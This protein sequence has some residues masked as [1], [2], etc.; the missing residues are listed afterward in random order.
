MFRHMTHENIGRRID[1]LKREPFD[2]CIDRTIRDDEPDIC[3][4]EL[5]L[6]FR[7]TQT[8]IDRNDCQF[9][10][11]SCVNSDDIT[12]AGRTIQSNAVTA[13]DLPGS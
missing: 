6:H 12:A 7:L 10:Q 13:G 1:Y 2:R 9:K 4:F 3:L 8:D 11:L 5:H